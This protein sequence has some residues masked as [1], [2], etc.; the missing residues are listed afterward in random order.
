M[1]EQ[2]ATLVEDS[3]RRP[4]A[5]QRAYACVREQLTRVDERREEL[6]VGSISLHEYREW[7]FPP[8]TLFGCV[9]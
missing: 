6:W 7:Y 5:H 8:A 3:V 1:V 4:D 2:L 9:C